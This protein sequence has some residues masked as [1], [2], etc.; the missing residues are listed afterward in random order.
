MMNAVVFIV[1]VQRRVNRQRQSCL[2]LD[3]A[4]DPADV[5]LLP[6]ANSGQAVRMECCGQDLA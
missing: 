2:R 3:V 5:G 1:Q 4:S 6:A